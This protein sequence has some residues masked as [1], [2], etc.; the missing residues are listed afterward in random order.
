MFVHHHFPC[1]LTLFIAVSRSVQH[2]MPSSLLH[3]ASALGMATGYVDNCV[4]M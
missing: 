2:R 4:L 3:Y 1:K